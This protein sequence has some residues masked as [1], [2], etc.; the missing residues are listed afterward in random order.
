MS[1]FSSSSHLVPFFFIS[2]LE[3]QPSTRQAD[4]EETQRVASRWPAVI[5]LALRRQDD[6]L[7]E[8]LQR[9]PEPVGSGFQLIGQ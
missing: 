8:S 7:Y 1:S 3:A 4:L 2:G 9:E 6:N 5:R